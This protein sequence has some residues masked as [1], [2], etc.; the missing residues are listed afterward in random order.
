[1][2]Q[3]ITI[4][5]IWMDR[6]MGWEEVKQKKRMDVRTIPRTSLGVAVRDRPEPGHARGGQARAP[7]GLLSRVCVRSRHRNYSAFYRIFVFTY[8]KRGDIISHWRRL[9][10]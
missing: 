2:N 1:M 5:V 3:K 9:I 7:A 10:I 8:V 6:W 4:K